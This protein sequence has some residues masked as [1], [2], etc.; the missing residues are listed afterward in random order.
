MVIKK[1]QRDFDATLTISSKLFGIIS[2]LLLPNQYLIFLLI[3]IFDTFFKIPADIYI[4][5]YNCIIFLI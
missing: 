3:Y 5:L 2:L 1:H 4:F